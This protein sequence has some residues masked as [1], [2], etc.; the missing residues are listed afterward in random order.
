MGGGVTRSYA[1]E[2]QYGVF[3]LEQET[4]GMVTPLYHRMSYNKRGQMT[5]LQL[6]SGA[7]ANTP[8][9]YN[10][11]RIQNFYAGNAATPL[12][13]GA[14][15]NGNLLA[16]DNSIPNYTGA[17]GPTT[18]RQVYDYDELN[19][20]KGASEY[21]NG[22]AQAQWR[23]QFDYDR[24]GNRT[25]NQAATTNGVPKPDFACDTATN[26]LLPGPTMPGAMAYDQAGNLTN[27]TATGAGG[28]VFDA[29]NRMISAQGN[30]VNGVS[31]TQF[32]TYDGDGQRIIRGPYQS[33]V[34][35]VYGFE[36]ELLAEY[37]ANSLKILPQKEYGYVGGK[38]LITANGGD[39]NR[40]RRFVENLYLRTWGYLPEGK[41]QTQINAIVAALGTNGQADTAA[42]L[43]AAKDLAA[44]LFD[45]S[46]YAN[47]SRT[48]EQYVADLYLAYL[49]RA[50][51]PGAIAW[52]A[53]FLNNGQLTR[54]QLRNE[55]ANG[56][57]FA[58]IVNALYGNQSG[59]YDRVDRLA[60]QVY[61]AATGAGPTATQLTGEQGRFNLAE[62]QGL[63]AVKEAA[64]ALGRDLLGANT[65]YRSDLST[66][67][68]VTRLYQ[69]F[70]RRAPDNGLS[71]YVTQADSQG[72]SSVLE[73]FLSMSAYTERSGALYREI[74]WLI[75][76]H[77]GTPR[78][79][80]ERTGSLAGLKRNDYLPFGESAN[81]L[82]GRATTQG[83]AGESVRQ[84]FTGYEED[85]E[86]GLHF[87]QA[88][89]L[90]ST[91]G[92]FISVDP[93][94]A[95]AATGEPQSWNRYVYV[96]NNPLNLTDP[97]GLLQ[98]PPVASTITADDVRSDSQTIDG[99]D[100]APPPPQDP[101]PPPPLPRVPTLDLPLP[102]IEPPLPTPDPNRL[103]SLADKSRQLSELTDYI[104]RS[105]IAPFVTNV[106]VGEDGNGKVTVSLKLSNPNGAITALDGAKDQIQNSGTGGAHT[107]EVGET[108][109]KN[110]ADFRSYTQGE[111]RLGPKSLQID[112]GRTTG[113]ARADLDRTN[114][115]QDVAGAAVHTAERLG[116]KAR[117]I[118]GKIF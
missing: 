111:N 7:T 52:Y 93:L 49:Q 27:D 100:D 66:T 117:R 92:R 89:Y 14:N 24:W 5:E 39:D 44:G 42:M 98:K 51:E 60:N 112:I 115:T 87:A 4:Y 46:Q 56:P 54:L 35:Q 34:W 10:R 40:L 90:S 30:V 106:T 113:R 109:K 25:I 11:G 50:P 18:F 6:G 41:G 19:R 103:A 99:A 22:G 95:S 26:R 108:D 33:G 118:F 15:N 36:G 101:S 114:P 55:F 8:D 71:G 37:A 96:S 97:T 23:Q 63:D 94:M 48:N 77:L 68:Y 91:Q 81:A 45:S 72:R 57:E 105:P 65:G 17:T 82:G 102:T 28:R 86:T 75:S 83:Y 110:V 3:G 32:Y 73:A 64:K 76:D 62:A 43:Q 69:T 53:G 31:V 74:F 9:A 80:A 59:D 107:K 29:E 116:N 13:E 12:T 20:L 16:Q 2:L 47:V 67:E 88:R 1:K 70:L 61:T 21:Y 79:I 78:M 58:W 38:L 85:S 104:D 84:G